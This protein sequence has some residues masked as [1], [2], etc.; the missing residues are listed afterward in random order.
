MRALSSA[1]T[2][3]FLDKVTDK[4]VELENKKIRTYTGNYSEFL[5]KKATQQKAIEKKYENDIK[6]IER[7]E[8][9]IA[10]QKQ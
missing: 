8:G 3:I 5:V 2:D 10:Q 1:T 9:I 4:T 6:E 7:L